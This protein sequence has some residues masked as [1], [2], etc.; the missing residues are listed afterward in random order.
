MFVVHGTFPIKPDAVGD[1]QA[2]LGPL[3]A[4]TRREPGCVFYEWAQSVE[5][6]GTFYSVE[7]WRSRD[8][9]DAHM[10]TDHVAAALAGLPDML[11]GQ[12]HLAGFDGGDQIDLPL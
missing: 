2:A 5:T 12:P 11:A 9:L 1:L 6:P 3:T 10:T 8:D 4:E 7:V